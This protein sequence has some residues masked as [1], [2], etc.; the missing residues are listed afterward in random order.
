M[1][2][3]SGPPVRARREGNESGFSSP[4]GGDDAT[5]GSEP[6]SKEQPL[7]YSSAVAN[8]KTTYFAAKLTPEQLKKVR[9]I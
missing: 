4:A 6:C 2:W 9:K 1:S 3:F 5:A 8:N 7:D